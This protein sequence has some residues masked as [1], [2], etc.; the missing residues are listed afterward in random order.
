[1]RTIVVADG[2]AKVR[3][4]LWV[5]VWVPFTTRPLALDKR[6]PTG[7]DAAAKVAHGAIAGYYRTAACCLSLGSQGRTALIEFFVEELVVV[8][9]AAK[10]HYDRAYRT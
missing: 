3:R 2:R 4:S 5:I 8:L 9:F 6:V 7:R 10:E 1:M